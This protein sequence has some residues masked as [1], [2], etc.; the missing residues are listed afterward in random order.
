MAGGSM[1]GA[2][3]G[4]TAQDLTQLSSIL[5][6]FGGGAGGNSGAGGMNPM[7][8]MGLQM[9]MRPP[10]GAAP[11]PMASMAHPAVQAQPMQGPMPPQ[12]M[13]VGQGMPQGQML[14]WMAMMR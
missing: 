12:M 5:Q 10:G 7:T 13:G 1:G 11:T 4:G 8:N 3:G 2:G 9:L 6:R 14:P